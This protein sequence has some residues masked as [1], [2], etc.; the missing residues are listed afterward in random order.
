M[1]CVKNN[2]IQSFF[3]PYFAAFGLNTG[4]KDQK[5]SVF[6]QFSRSDAELSRQ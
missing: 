4:K 1:H 5:D 3:G 6:G 2:Q